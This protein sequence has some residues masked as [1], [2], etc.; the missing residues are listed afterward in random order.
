MSGKQAEGDA[1]WAPL[2]DSV[3]KTLKLAQQCKDE[4]NFIQAEKH[5]SSAIRCML[6][7][8]LEKVRDPGFEQFFKDQVNI[9]LADLEAVKPLADAQRHALRIKAKRE[10]G[11]EAKTDTASRQG[12]ATL[13]LAGVKVS[14]RSSF[15]ISLND[16]GRE[17]SPTSEYYHSLLPS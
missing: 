1:D 7:E 11:D 17:R 9:Y 8:I 2:V 5:Y 4:S 10:D 3:E 16:T 12:T 15:P 6:F 14:L 13:T